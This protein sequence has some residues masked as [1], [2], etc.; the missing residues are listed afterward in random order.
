MKSIKKIQNP[1]RRTWLAGLGT[2][3]KGREL[4]VDKFDNLVEQTQ[5]GLN[6]LISRGAKI[7]A[8]LQAN[9]KDKLALPGWL[10]ERIDAI[11][12]RLRPGPDALMDAADKLEK[13]LNDLDAVVTA[14]QQKKAA[15]EAKK[16]VDSVA[17][18]ALTAEKAARTQSASVA[19]DKVTSAAKPATTNKASAGRRSTAKPATRRAATK[20]ASPQAAT[21]RRSK[22]SQ[23]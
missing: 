21:N 22:P 13:A 16:A 4:A 9:L 11:K 12:A 18:K 8:Q 17:S 23:S 3:E 5:S 20:P 1:G 2:Y 15:A 14:L 6:D 10:S 7:E 19:N